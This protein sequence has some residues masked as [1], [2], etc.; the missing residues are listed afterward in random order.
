M[1][2]IRMPAF[3]LYQSRNTEISISGWEEDFAGFASSNP[4][5]KPHNLLFTYVTGCHPT[6]RG[7]S[8]PGNPLVCCHVRYPPERFLWLVKKTTGWRSRD[9][10][11]NRRSVIHGI[12][13]VFNGT[14]VNISRCLRAL[15]FH[16]S[17]IYPHQMHLKLVPLITLTFSFA[18]P[19]ITSLSNLFFSV[20]ILCK[21]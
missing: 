18:L 16:V 17:F 12:N 11:F 4:P 9:E 13:L 5:L 20:R 3:D 14:P 6:R 8:D 7:W 2:S 15:S 1:T 21:W 10:E 19:T